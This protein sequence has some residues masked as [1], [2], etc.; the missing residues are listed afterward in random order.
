MKRR[1]TSMMRGKAGSDGPELSIA[2][3]IDVSFLL[4]IF[5]IVTTTILKRERD[6]AL[7][8]PVPGEGEVPPMSIVVG[9]ES[10]GTIVLNPGVGALLI[11]SDLGQRELPV[12]EDHVATIRSVAAEREV[13]VQLK[14]GEE[15]RQQRVV[16]VLN[17]FAKVG[18]TTVALA[19]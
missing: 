3:L 1:Q 17:C 9:V 2:P 6:L 13:M 10:D 18:I 7:Q 16:D 5:F 4:L 14:V 8:L 11:S 19:D 12:L 15:A